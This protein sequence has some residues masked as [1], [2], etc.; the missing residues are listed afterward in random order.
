M[1]SNEP[2]L[3]TNKISTSH[4]LQRSDFQG[5]QR[6]KRKRSAIA[7]EILESSAQIDI[8]N[9]KALEPPV[10]EAKLLELES[11][12]FSYGVLSFS[13]VVEDNLD[14][15][16]SRFESL[17]ANRLLCRICG[18][19][20]E[21][22]YLICAS[23]C[24]VYHDFCASCYG[25]CQIVSIENSTETVTASAVWTCS[26]CRTC[27]ICGDCL[28]KDFIVICS[29]CGCTAHKSCQKRTH[30]AFS[31]DAENVFVCD[32]CKT[33]SSL[34]E[35]NLCNEQTYSRSIS[36]FM[37]RNLICAVCQTSYVDSSYWH[38]SKC[39]KFVHVSCESM[40]PTVISALSV[41]ELYSYRCPSCRIKD[42]QPS[43]KL[44]TIN[45][46]SLLE[47]SMQ[48]E[49]SSAALSCA[50]YSESIFSR[51][52]SNVPFYFY[53]VN[54]RL[55]IKLKKCDQLRLEDLP[56]IIRLRYSV[57]QW[58]ELLKNNITKKEMVLND[59]SDNILTST[60]ENYLPSIIL[61]EA[62]ENGNSKFSQNSI[63]EQQFNHREF[64]MSQR[65][66]LGRL[67]PIFDHSYFCKIRWVHSLCALR[68]A[69]AFE[70]DWGFIHAVRPAISRS[71]HAKCSLCKQIG[72][73][74]GCYKSRCPQNYHLG[75]A[76]DTAGDFIDNKI[77]YCAK[78][79]K[80][81]NC[82]ESVPNEDKLM[83]LQT[84]IQR[85]LRIV[86]DRPNRQEFPVSLASSISLRIGSFMLLKPGYFLPE[87]VDFHDN[88]TLFPFGYTSCRYFWGIGNSQKLQLYLFHITKDN[89]KKPVFEV[90]ILPSLSTGTWIVRGATPEEA[91]NK[92]LEQDVNI[93]TQLDGRQAFGLSIPAVAF[94][95]EH[96]PGVASCRN[97]QRRFTHCK[98]SLEEN[99]KYDIQEERCNNSGCI[100]TEPFQKANTT[101]NFTRESEAVV[102]HSS[103][104]VPTTERPNSLEEKTSE[105]VPQN[106]STAYRK[107]RKKCGQRCQIRRSGIQGFGLYAIEDIPE[108]EL[109]IE[110]AG[111]IIRPIIADIREKDYERR[112]IG[113]YMFRLNEYQIVDATVK[114]NYARFI[115]HSCNPNC[116]SKIIVIDGGRQV[117]GIFAKKNILQ[118]E[119]L[120]YDYQ[121]DEFGET[122]PCNCGAFNCRGKMN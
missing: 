103:Y 64:H 4:A 11:F 120:T 35:N 22:N 75:C 90:Y 14:A 99:Q 86:P 73:T 53:S 118:G 122:I 92:F 95:L 116:L 56:N 38:C 34:L 98:N 77:F 71:R 49:A 8:R 72:A 70:D 102:S 21:H 68:S 10:I 2:E 83:R 76:M 113:C 57:L 37:A 24:D 52:D 25:I 114:G 62:N 111:E 50:D 9:S 97:Y 36:T 7:Q 26:Y 121:F 29:C 84:S 61:K 23:C 13:S 96:L 45:L 58:I 65:I 89:S 20:V 46:S 101:T 94:T 88:T 15:F 81:F 17:C 119:E 67:L 5:M 91:W 43:L 16:V 18:S 104:L 32:H 69:E 40:D 31:D 39:N 66:S 63:E 79:M 59:H 54:G 105:P 115:N 107:M 44:G 87:L 110:Y 100:R 41:C 48:V 3:E 82:A 74:V 33:S 106:Y 42:P 1:S 60:N 93:K 112:K 51:N 47:Q 109:I 108:D 19:E 6:K 28:A 27:N 30:S 55:C 117:I 78:H 85:C 80:Q 12:P